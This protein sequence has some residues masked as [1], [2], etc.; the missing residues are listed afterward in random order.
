[1]IF[2]GARISRSQHIYLDQ[3]LLKYYVGRQKE[4]QLKT[5]EIEAVILI[6]EPDLMV[7]IFSKNQTLTIDRLPTPDSHREMVKKLEFALN[8]L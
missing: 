1:M 8:Q 4:G 3:S 6:A 5:P 2:Q 7:L